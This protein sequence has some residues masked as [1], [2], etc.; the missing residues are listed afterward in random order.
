MH[1]DVIVEVALLRRVEVRVVFF[2]RYLEGV[3]LEG[4]EWT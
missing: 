3:S 2:L 4:A 1:R